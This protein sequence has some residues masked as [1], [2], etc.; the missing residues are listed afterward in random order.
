MNWKLEPEGFITIKN[1]NEKI[2]RKFLGFD[3]TNIPALTHAVIYAIQ[4]EEGEKV[5]DDYK[6]NIFIY[7]ENDSGG[8]L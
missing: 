2:V 3:K 7:N 4:T 6:G 8:C 5:A 1:G